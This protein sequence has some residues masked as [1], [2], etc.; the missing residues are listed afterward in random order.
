MREIKFRGKDTKTGEWRYGYYCVQHIQDE[1]D[2][3]HVSVGYQ[4]VHVIFNDEPGHRHK[5]G[6]WHEVLCNT[7]GQFTGRKD[8]HFDEIY[9]GDIVRDHSDPMGDGDVGVVVYD[10]ERAIFSI[11]YYSGTGES[12]TYGMYDCKQKELEIIGNIHD[13]PELLKED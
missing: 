12:I 2:N 13:N 9:D 10:A 3:G 1:A 7:I 5:N 8:L 11:R 4:H 6:Y